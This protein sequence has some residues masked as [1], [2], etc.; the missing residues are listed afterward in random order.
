VGY[1][2]KLNKEKPILDRITETID[3]IA[4]G[5]GYIW[6]HKEA[7]GGLVAA[8]YVMNTALGITAGIMSVIVA[9]EMASGIGLI[10]IAIE[11]II[12]ILV[13]A[14]FKFENWRKAINA[15]FGGLIWFVSAFIKSLIKVAQFLG[16]I[17]MG[18]NPF[19]RYADGADKA[20]KSIDKTTK[21]MDK[22]NKTKKKISYRSLIS[23]GIRT[24][25]KASITPQGIPAMAGGYATD[26]SQYVSS[27][28]SRIVEET[29]TTKEQKVVIDINDK[30][31]SAE[32]NKEKSSYNELNLNLSN[33]GGF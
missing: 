11:A 4:A 1:I 31:G 8:I 32:V 16:D 22:L 9:L 25:S 21:A 6:E 20:T 2:K 15:V 5:V 7:I 26:A 27:P 30:S 3:S 14:Y 19:A 18:V 24:A 28:E 10:V 13:I 23:S 29:K 33:S 12:A 17:A